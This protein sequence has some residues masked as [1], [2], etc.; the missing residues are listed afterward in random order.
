MNIKSGADSPGQ[1]AMLQYL[2]CFAGP[3][4]GSP[5]FWGGLHVRVRSRKPRP[6]VDEHKLQ[7]VHSSQAPSTI[8]GI[9][10]GWSLF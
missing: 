4:Q 2:V 7:G 1:T 6:H 9:K 5:P 3:T 10:G 8:H